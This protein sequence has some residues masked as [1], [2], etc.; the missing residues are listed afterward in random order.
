[1]TV[2]RSLVGG[3][4]AGFPGYNAAGVVGAER[5]AV[6]PWPCATLASIVFV[7]AVGATLGSM[8]RDRAGVLGPEMKSCS[9]DAA[10]AVWRPR[11]L[12]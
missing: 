7:P 3:P 4:V 8:H 10:A 2:A 5:I 11:R 12:R 9:G 6:T 1:M